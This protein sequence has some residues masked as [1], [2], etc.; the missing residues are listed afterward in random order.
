MREFLWDIY[1]PR[2]GMTESEIIIIVMILYDFR[3]KQ[4]LSDSQ[5]S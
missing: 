2:D 1:I 5:A 3:K 4:S